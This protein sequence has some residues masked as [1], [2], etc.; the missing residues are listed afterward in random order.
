MDHSGSGLKRPANRRSFLKNG[1]L[2]VGAA[3]G[4]GLLRNGSLAYAGQSENNGPA[5]TKG[6]IAI[7]TFLSALEQVEADLWIQYAELGGP[8]T[9]VAGAEGLSAIDLQLNGKAISTGLAPGYVTALQVLDGDM[10][11]YIGDNTDD[12]I[13]H[14]RFLNNY[15]QSKGAAPIDLSHFAVIPPSQVTGVPQTGRLTNLRQLTVDTTWWTRLRSDNQNPDLGGT[16]E[17]AIPDLAK[18]Q[19]PAI[20]QTNAEAALNN[21]GSIP[22]HLQAIASTAGFHFAFIEQGGASLYPS[23]AQKV[24]NLEVLRVLLSIGPSEAMHFQTWH[25][26]AGNAPNITDGDLTFPNLNA[27]IDPNTGSTTVKGTP[28]ADLFQTNL[29]M[30][31]PTIFLDPKLGP[32]SILRPTS[33]AQGGAVASVVSFVEDGLFIDPATGS[34]TGIVD[35]LMRLAEEADEVRRQL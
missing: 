13:S 26:K 30:P 1:A 31:E 3:V 33:T 10:P 19:H 18:G 11:Q 4:V 2:G 12:E 32:V 14:H 29:I 28:A 35:R 5:I 17:Q 9:A 21:D 7:L 34:N 27:G 24:T 22:N 23:L 15:L 16:F 6:D 8:T 25:D 20:P